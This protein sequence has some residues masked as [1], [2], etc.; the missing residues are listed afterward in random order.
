FQPKAD[1]AAA[2]VGPEERLALTD[3]AR[4]VGMPDRAGEAC[5]LAG[6]PV[7]GHIGPADGAGGGL[8][9]QSLAELLDRGAPVLQ[10][11]PGAPAGT[12][13][14][15]PNSSSRRPSC[16]A[17]R[18]SAASKRRPMPRRRAAGATA[19]KPPAAWRL[20]SLKPQLTVP[21]PRTPPRGSR[22]T[23]S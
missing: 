16:R 6:H 17:P 7:P 11:E 15:S 12:E 9:L 21:K 13:S 19:M 18:I 20:L 10:I 3:Q 22:T 8:G 5:Q 1:A 14:R 2:I 4:P 23:Q